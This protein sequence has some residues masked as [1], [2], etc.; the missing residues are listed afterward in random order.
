MIDDLG[1]QS[2]S[3]EDKALAS[4]CDEL[5]HKSVVLPQRESQ[6]NPH[7]YFIVVDSSN[8][9]AVAASRVV[10]LQIEEIKRCIVTS[11]HSI[12]HVC[13]SISLPFVKNNVC[14]E[15][16]LLSVSTVH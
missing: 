5:G 1:S 2:L 16:I 6:A 9:E 4:I 15:K 7:K 10:A 12:H 14:R 11:S 3:G 8:A 13:I